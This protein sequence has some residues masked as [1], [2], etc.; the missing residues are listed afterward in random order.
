M[1]QKQKEMKWLNNGWQL[2]HESKTFLENLRVYLFSNGKNPKEIEEITEELEIHLLEAEKDGKSIEKIIGKSPKEY[3]EMLSNEMVIDYRTWMKYICLIIFGSF[4]FTI[5]PDL[6]NGNLSYSI[7][8]IFG[9]IL[10]GIIFIAAVLTGFKLTATTPQ[11]VKKTN[12]HTYS[13]YAAANRPV[14]WLDLPEQSHRYASHSVWSR[15]KHYNRSNYRL[16]HYRHVLLGK[17]MDPPHHHIL[18]NTAGLFLAT[19][20]FT[21]GA[22]VTNQYTYY[23]WRSCNLSL[24]IS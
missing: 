8:E 7:L 13:S 2:S 5:F 19:D 22:T 10:I 1:N 9:H 6:L 4:S 17:N 12:N 21:A 16:A 3:M 11:S 23:L 14:H 20:T 15:W 18:V 24:V